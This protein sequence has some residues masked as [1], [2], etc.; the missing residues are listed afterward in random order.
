MALLAEQLVD[1]WLNRQGFFTLRGIRRGNDEID[2][3]GIRSGHAGLEGWHV[4]VQVSFRPVGY[5]GKLSE[6]DQLAFGIEGRNS[7]RHRDDAVLA[8]GVRT[9]V[10]GKFGGAVKHAMREACWQGI[11]WHQLLVHGKVKAPR[12]LEF[13]ASHGIEIVPMARV[14]AE[15]CDARHGQ[16]FGA[17]GTD[18]AELI[19]FYEESR[20]AA[21]TPNHTL[22]APTASGVRRRAKVAV[23]T[24]FGG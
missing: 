3:L 22:A 14:L 12:E 9:W 1:E 16:I 24:P 23:R 20:T 5:I 7:A 15:V 6:K 10:D 17:A 8:A 21:Q 19:R 13:I 4:E 11:K 2:L 18:V